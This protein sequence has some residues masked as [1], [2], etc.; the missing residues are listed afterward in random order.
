MIGHLNPGIEPRNDWELLQLG[1][2]RYQG[3]QA[4]V[5]TALDKKFELMSKDEDLVQTQEDWDRALDTLFEPTGIKPY[6]GE[7]NECIQSRPIPDTKYSIRLFPDFST[8]AE[9]CLDFVDNE[10][11]EAVNFPFE[12]ELFAGPGETDAPWLNVPGAMKSHSIERV[13]GNRQEDIL[14]GEEKF[15]L[16]DGQMCVLTRPG[17]PAIHFTVPIRKRPT[18]ENAQATANIIRLDF[19]KVITLAP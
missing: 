15:I 10:T 19:P 4:E 17:K 3:G 7:Q 6:A 14:P 18:D 12:F 1:A 9:Y 5:Y 2:T 11:G 8:G 13:F 16:R